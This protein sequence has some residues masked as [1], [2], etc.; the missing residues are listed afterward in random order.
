[1]REFQGRWSQIALGFVVFEL[2]VLVIVEAYYI[3]REDL[4]LDKRN[5]V[6][7]DKK[8]AEFV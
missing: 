3:Y 6:N 8:K 7:D 5:D 4:F 1:M 2:I